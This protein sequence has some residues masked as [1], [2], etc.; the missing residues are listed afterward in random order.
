MI[1]LKVASSSILVFSLLIFGCS[2]SSYKINNSAD[3]RTEL[4]VSPDRILLECEFIYDYTGDIKEAH[5]FMMHVLDD[6]NTVLTVNQ[7]NI[8]GKEDCFRRINKIGKILK[9]GKRIFIGGTGDL[10]DSR[11]KENEQY[12]FPSLGT[13]YFNGRVLQ[14]IVVWNENGQCYN[15][16]MGDKKPCP[17]GEFP[18]EKPK[19]L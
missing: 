6:E 17:S 18:I 10:K 15:T 9:G 12:V 11:V 13:F 8:L 16:Y 3:F 1:N 2:T 4:V 5:G 7:G 19:S 14:F